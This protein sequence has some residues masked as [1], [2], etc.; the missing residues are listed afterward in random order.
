MYALQNVSF[1]SLLNISLH[2][3]HE[4]IDSFILIKLSKS[5]CMEECSFAFNMNNNNLFSY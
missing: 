1:N 2:R 4:D 5:S 3:E